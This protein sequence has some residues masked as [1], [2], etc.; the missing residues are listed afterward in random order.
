MDYDDFTEAPE[1]Y[2]E[3]SAPDSYSFKLSLK[4]NITTG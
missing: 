1:D 2:F 3:P 4:R